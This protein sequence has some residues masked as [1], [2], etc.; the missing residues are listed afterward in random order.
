[1]KTPHR[2]L[3]ITEHDF[4]SALYCVVQLEDSLV[5]VFDL[6]SSRTHVTTVYRSTDVRILRYPYFPTQL[7]GKHQAGKFV[8]ISNTE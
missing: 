3:F 5:E 4:R 2:L 7:V 8:E 1:M 6:F